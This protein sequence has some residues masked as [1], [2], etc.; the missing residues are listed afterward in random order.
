MKYSVFGIPYSSF[1]RTS[2]WDH[3]ILS[4]S[5]FVLSFSTSLRT[6][7]H[8]SQTD[9]LNFRII[10]ATNNSIFR[11][12]KQSDNSIFWFFEQSNER[13]NTLVRKGYRTS[14]FKSQSLSNDQFSNFCFPT[15]QVKMYNISPNRQYQPAIHRQSLLFI[16]CQTWPFGVRI[17]WT[18]NFAQLTICRIAKPANRIDHQSFFSWAQQKI[19]SLSLYRIIY[20]LVFIVIRGE[21]HQR[22]TAI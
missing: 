10:E 16:S 18:L 17:T 7:E 14:I 21:I 2:K 8:T 5:Q 13:T 11:I 9:F 3:E 15:Y 12:I 20:P 22:F 4:L 6:N 19:V 1:S